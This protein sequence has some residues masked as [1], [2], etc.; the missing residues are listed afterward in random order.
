MKEYRSLLPALSL[1]LFLVLPG[2]SAPGVE[3]GIQRLTYSI[4]FLGITV[5]RAVLDEVRPEDPDGEWVVRGGARTTAF[6]NQFTHIRNSYVTCFRA[7]DFNPSVYERKIDEK[8]IRFRQLEWYGEGGA[9]SLPAGRLPAL[10][11][12]YRT[13]GEPARNSVLQVPEDHGN[14]FSAL[15]WARYSDWDNNAVATRMMWVEGSTWRLSVRRVGTSTERVPGGKVD[16]WELRCT[17]EKL[18]GKE[19]NAGSGAAPGPK[20]DYVTRHLIRE[21]V[22]ITLWIARETARRPVKVKVAMPRITVVGRLKEPLSDEL[23]IY[24]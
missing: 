21:D 18:E 1:I 6:W 13:R 20:T 3:E 9:T 14:F 8:G 22:V 23:L 19:P 12:K 11:E 17:L 16:T 4:N 24:Q 5:A 15:W 10:P 7:T 2:R